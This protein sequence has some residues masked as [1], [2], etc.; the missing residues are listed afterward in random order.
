MK[1]LLTYKLSQDHLGLYFAAVRS[2]FGCNNKPH[3]RKDIDELENVQRRATKMVEGSE[4][5][6]FSNRPQ[7]L[8]LTTLETRLL[9]ADLIE[10]FEILR[11]YENIDHERL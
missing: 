7:I 6:S 8:G 10:V 11:G 5:Y 4:G 2:S 9:R 3:Y 1:Y